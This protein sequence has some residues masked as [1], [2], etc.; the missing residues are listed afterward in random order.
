[1]ITKSIDGD[2][3]LALRG[4]A[5]TDINMLS[6]S[7][8]SS[9]ADQKVLQVPTGRGVRSSQGV[10]RGTAG[11]ELLTMRSFR[12]PWSGAKRFPPQ[13]GGGW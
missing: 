2:F 7:R 1:M 3:R 13:D 6:W 8:T 4:A 5:D 9:L 12:L 11:H 10:S